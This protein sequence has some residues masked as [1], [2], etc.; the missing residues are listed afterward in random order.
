[1]RVDWIDLTDDPGVCSFEVE[2]GELVAVC[3]GLDLVARFAGDYLDDTRHR[4]LTLHDDRDQ[5]MNALI[6]L[7]VGFGDFSVRLLSLRAWAAQ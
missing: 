5:M 4:P 7:R 3:L 2:Q 6:A 1:M